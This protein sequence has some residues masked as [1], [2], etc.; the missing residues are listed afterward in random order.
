M[1]MGVSLT[2]VVGEGTLYEHRVM[3]YLQEAGVSLCLPLM[4]VT[5]LLY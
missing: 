2:G 1:E 5:D 4:V 3:G